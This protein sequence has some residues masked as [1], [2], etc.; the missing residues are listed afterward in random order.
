MKLLKIFL[1]IFFLCTFTAGSSQKQSNP[2][3]RQMQNLPYPLQHP[4]SMPV[5]Y[6]A[7]PVAPYPT[8][9]PPPMPATYNPYATMPYPTQG[10]L[11]NFNA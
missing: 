3:N 6:G 8:Y 2:E 9:M 10:T 4:G 7:S 5:P 11:K 1:K